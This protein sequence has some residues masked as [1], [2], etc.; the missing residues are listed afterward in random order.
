MIFLNIEK[1]TSNS[2]QCKYSDIISFTK[3]FF[4]NSFIS[5]VVHVTAMAY[6]TLVSW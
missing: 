2:V 1:L 5:E 4:I 3:H 6:P